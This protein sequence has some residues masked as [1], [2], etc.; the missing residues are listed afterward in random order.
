[1]TPE[2]WAFLG[3]LLVVIG[4]LVRGLFLGREKEA[5]LNQRSEEDWTEE[6]HRILGSQSNLIR[7]LEERLGAAENKLTALEK[8]V[9]TYKTSLQAANT[10]IRE[11]E[12][13]VRS[14]QG[15]YAMQVALNLE[16]AQQVEALTERMDR[17]GNDN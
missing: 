16:L 8:E 15:K 14:W 6:R 7:Q 4:T 10:H 11:L 5:E 12:A 9:S 17:N 1:L 3:T 2:Q 13:E